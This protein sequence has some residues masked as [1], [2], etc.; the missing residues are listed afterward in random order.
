MQC[1]TW[2]WLVPLVRHVLQHYY[3]RDR[4]EGVLELVSAW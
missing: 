1:R 4:G 2:G 3:G